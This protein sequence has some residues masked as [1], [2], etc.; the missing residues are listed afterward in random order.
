MKLVQIQFGV[1]RTAVAEAVAG[2]EELATGCF[3]GL[4]GTG[5]V[6]AGAGLET[7]VAT[8]LAAAGRAEAKPPA[9]FNGPCLGPPPFAA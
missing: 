5:G 9:S 3:F 2:A 6:P 8:G 1:L 4:A 7:G